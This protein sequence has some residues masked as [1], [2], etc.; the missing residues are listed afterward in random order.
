MAIAFDDRIKSNVSDGILT[1]GDQILLSSTKDTIDV[2]TN[3]V[4]KLSIGTCEQDITFPTNISI[5]TLEEYPT[6][7][8]NVITAC[9]N[10]TTNVVSS[11]IKCINSS[12]NANT[13]SI[14]DNIETEY[15]INISSNIDST[16]IKSALQ[17]ISNLF[18]GKNTVY[19]YLGANIKLNVGDSTQLVYST[20]SDKIFNEL[21]TI[22][23]N[24][25]IK[26]STINISTH[27]DNKYHLQDV[28]QILILPSTTNNVDNTTLENRITKLENLLSLSSNVD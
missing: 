19:G 5:K 20:Q 11:A 26:V 27:E 18:V 10:A 15:I 7:L 12:S 16:N 28:M 3:I 25:L 21:N 9:L 2:G 13:N 22:P 24:T 8:D 17:S 6:T 23:R 14:F 1:T 4:K